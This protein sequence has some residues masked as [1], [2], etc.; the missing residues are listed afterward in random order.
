MKK[1]LSVILILGLHL[2]A[3][4]QNVGIGT[5][6]PNASA[7]LEVTATNKGFLLPR[8]ALTGSADAVT[9]PSPATSLLIYNTAS[10]GAG[11]AAVT[12]GYYFWNG[13][14]W[15]QLST[16]IS[17]AGWSLTGNSGTSIANNFISL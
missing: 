5:N 12:P 6:A 16:N 15:L 4:A 11:L 3:Y 1:I 8:I 2:F 9:I 10:A 17:S 7:R 13:S 14:K